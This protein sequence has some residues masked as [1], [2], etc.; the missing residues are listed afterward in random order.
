MTLTPF[1]LL[2]TLTICALLVLLALKS[3]RLPT[4]PAY[5]IAGLIAGPSGLGLLH[6]GEEA[7]F[8]AE[9]GVILLMFTIGLN[10]NRSALWSI[11]R[12]A[13]ILGGLQ[14][15]LTALVFILIA[16]F[17]VEGRLLIFLIACTA[18]MS[19]TAIASQILIEEREVVSPVGRRT[20]G[21]L[22]FQDFLVIP[23]I[24]IFSNPGEGEALLWVSLALLAKI[25]VAFVLVLWLGKYLMSGWLARIVR[26]GDRELFMINLVATIIFS[27]WLTALLDLSPAL[28]AFLAGIL[29]AETV[30][31][32]RVEQIVEPFRQLLLGFFFMTLGTLISP[33]SLFDNALVILSLATGVVVAKILIIR[34][35]CRIVKT[36]SRTAWKTALLLCGT[37]EF[38]FV[39]M[40]VAADSEILPPPLMEILIPVNIL[41]LMC[42][43]LLWAKSQK[44]VNWLSRDDWVKSANKRAENEAKTHS[45][46]D[47]VIVCGFG[48][49]GQSIVGIMR[50]T[51]TPVAVLEDDYSVLLLMKNIDSIFYGHGENPDSLMSVGILRARVLIVSF[52]DAVRSALTIQAARRLNPNIKIIAKAYTTAQAEA[53]QKLGGDEVFV[54][55]YESGF[56]MANEALRR[57]EHVSGE[58]ISAVVSRAR[59]R[60]NPLFLGRLAGDRADKEEWG[61]A[62]LACRV[63]ERFD[64]ESLRHAEVRIVSWQRDGRGIPESEWAGHRPQPGDE[65]VLLGEVGR[66][67]QV[68][69]DLSQA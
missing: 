69:S 36:Y 65:L 68:K 42:V 27:S 34:L 64:D 59:E 18:V 39:L 54:E 57:L 14:A 10:F 9:L 8:A 51:S 47:H 58:T 37:G 67:E 29:I 21:V 2:A 17:F 28:G 26:Y 44:L 55:P 48:R 40:T 31:R 1:T 30:H 62:L 66:I 20:M 3:L 43:P 46:N 5:F 53:L 23:L 60:R 22:L 11:R 50:S 45:L 63:G 24:I 13:T 33:Q 41:A 56:S 52:Y 32:Y 35:C 19:S 15:L 16:Q 61:E 38:G 7:D 6:T 49:T 4:I 25:V 12:Y